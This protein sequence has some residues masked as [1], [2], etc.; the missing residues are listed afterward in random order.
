MQLYVELWSARQAWR[1][2]PQSE[3]EQ[4]FGTVGQAIGGEIGAGGELLGVA[5]ANPAT[6]RPI[7]CQ[8]IAIWRVPDD[9]LPGFEA[10]WERIGWHRYFDQT[11]AR[12]TAIAPDAFIGQH[13]AL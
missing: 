4:F 7:D 5:A 13:L 1:D 10:T 8:F 3:R 12:G 6:D 2:L 9:R 11:N